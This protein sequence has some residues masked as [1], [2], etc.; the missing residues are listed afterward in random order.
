MGKGKGSTDA[1]AA[2]TA[3]TES[4]TSKES[5]QQK[6]ADLAAKVLAEHKAKQ[7]TGKQ[8]AEEK[9]RLQAFKDIAEEEPSGQKTDVPPA[10]SA[11]KAV[12]Y[13]APKA[14]AEAAA[15]DE[16]ATVSADEVA[17]VP[18]EKTAPTIIGDAS[19]QR[20]PASE[21]GWFP[22]SWCTSSRKAPPRYYD[23]D[24]YY[25]LPESLRHSWYRVFG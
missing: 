14:E 21:S 15:A 18:A 3:V 13:Q 4:K 22:F 9:K 16:W 17:S 25:L 11:D 10:T 24:H 12:N 23:S 20:P 1:R 19:K 2:A 6:K 8:A 7:K 5:K